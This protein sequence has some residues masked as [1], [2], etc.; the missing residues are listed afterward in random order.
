M[1]LNFKKTRYR[2]VDLD[3]KSGQRKYRS[4]K[5]SNDMLMR[6]EK[7]IPLG[8]Q[9][10]SK[11][12]LN[13]VRGA[14]PFFL[15]RG[16]GAH[17]WDID[18]NEYIDFLLALMPVILGYNDTDVNHAINEQ[19]TKGISFSLASE[20]EV[21]LAEKLI[22]LIP[23]AEMVRFGKNGSD[24][25][26]GALRVSRAF[27][28]RDK[29]AVCGYHS[30]H[31]WY[32]SATHYNL[33]VP[34]IEKSLINT[35]Q[36]NNLDSLEE[37]LKKE[38]DNYAAIIMEPAN[39]VEPHAG[40]LEGVRALADQYGVV[41]VFDEIVTGWRAHLSGA[42]FL[43]GV[44]PDL[45]CFGKAMGNGMPISAL[46]GRKDIMQ[47]VEKVFLSSTFGGETLSIAAA[48]ATIEKMIATDAIPKMLETA[49]WLRENINQ[50]ILKHKMAEYISIE[51]VTW[52]PRVVWN[53][54][55]PE[56]KMLATSLLRQELAEAGILQGQ[57]LNICL[58]HH[59]EIT[60]NEIINRWDKALSDLLPA[61]SSDNPSDHLRGSLMKPPFQVR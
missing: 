27:T 28:G 50:K 22:E 11:S 18:G 33:G 19:M 2:Q 8:T 16:Q 21:E 52:W 25:T 57:G 49:S 37:L 5:K 34:S 55:A 43:Y 51:G 20:L 48:I 56:D 7:I 30:W 42:Q 31:D 47:I 9:T 46:V 54:A 44:T 41:L 14:F 24:V 58:S 1:T 23:C 26:A 29:V 61:F 6:A 60:R 15:E 13:F 32:I 12:H 4:F 35:F 17:V 45:S 36:Y 10:F 53:E 39:A 38:P 59:D 40:F 3:N